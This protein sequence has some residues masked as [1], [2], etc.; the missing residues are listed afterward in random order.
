MPREITCEVLKVLD[1]TKVRDNTIRLRVVTWN[2]KNPQLE[3]REFWYDDKGD[4]K[5]GK[6]KGLNLSDLNKIVDNFDEIKTL[7]SK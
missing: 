5:M 2:G 6:A 3:K 1:E 4:E 7:M